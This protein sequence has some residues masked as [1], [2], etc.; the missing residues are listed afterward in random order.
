M[1]R[2]KIADRIL[3]FQAMTPTSGDTRNSDLRPTI[4]ED[5]SGVRPAI[6]WTG[7]FAVK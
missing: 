2:P 1:L 4:I 3:S 6:V 7:A 5:A